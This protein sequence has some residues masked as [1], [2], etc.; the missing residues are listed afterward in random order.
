MTHVLIAGSGLAGSALAI[1]LG[2]LGFSVE[3]F[4]RARFLGKTVRRRSHARR[5]CSDRTARLER[6]SG[7]T[8]RCV[9]APKAMPHCS[10]PTLAS[11][12]LRLEE[13]P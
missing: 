7:R 10:K 3:L 5:R 1:Q 4:E 12:R 6:Q 11:H 13:V 9:C 2:R 8:V